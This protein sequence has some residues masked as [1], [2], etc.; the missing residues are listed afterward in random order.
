MKITLDLSRFAGADELDRR[1]IRVFG[2]IEEIAKKYKGEPW[3]IKVGRCQMCGTCCTEVADT[4]KWG[5]NPE[6]GA[7]LQLIEREGMPGPSPNGWAMLCRLALGRPFSC[8]AGDNAGQDHCS[9]VWE[10]LDE[11]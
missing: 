11:D 10:T 7:C 6:T 1:H 8:S 3:Q 5:K 4:W 9:V 2:G